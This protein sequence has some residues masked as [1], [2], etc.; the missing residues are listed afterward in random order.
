MNLAKQINEKLDAILHFNRE[1]KKVKQDYDDPNF[2][3]QD[4]ETGEK[5]TK[6]IVL[7]KA[8]EQY[9]QIIVDLNQITNN[10]K[11]VRNIF[12]N[13]YYINDAL[14]D[15][16]IADE[17]RLDKIEECLSKQNNPENN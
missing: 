16:L 14:Q 1:L 4:Q 12:N 8:R 9:D 15:K 7:N 10:G 2:A 6:E 3:L 13:P 5:V 17:I 11:N